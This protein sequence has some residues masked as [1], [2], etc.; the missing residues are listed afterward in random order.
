MAIGGTTLSAAIADSQLQLAGATATR[1]AADGLVQLAA[2]YRASGGG[3]TLALLG[4]NPFQVIATGS[5][6]YLYWSLVVIFLGIMGVTALQQSLRGRQTM[7]A[8]HPL[9]ALA[10]VNFRLLLGSLIIANTP[11]LY[12]LLITVSTAVSDGVQAMGAQAMGNLLQNGGVGP[13]TFAQARL[14]AIRSAAAR[15][16]IALHPAGASRNEMVQLGLWYNAMANAIN[17]GLSGQNLPG[18][19]PLLDPSI[20]TGA[21]TP[22]DRVAATV[23]RT[24]VQN[25]GPM[26]ADLAAL[27][28]ADGPLSI[29][30][31]EGQAALLPPLS[32]A[33][34]ADDSQANAAL[35][36]AAVPSNDAAWE[37]AR[38]L[39][40]R[41]VLADTL[42]YLDGQI[43]PILGAS[44]TLAQ[45]AQAWFSDQVE[46]AAASAGGFLGAMRAAVDWAGR[47]LGVVLTRLV[48]FLFT[49][50]VRVLIEANLFVLV[51]AMPFWL[52]P[53]T[54]EAFYGVLRSLA[55]LAVM[56][57]AYQ[58]IMLFVD[59]LMALV[60]KYI[61]LGPLAAGGGSALAAAGGA[62]YTATAALAVVGSGGEIV[63]LATFCYL[64]TYL[65]LAVYVAFKTPKLIAVFLRGA[66]A[67]GA[68]LSTFAT[69]LIAGASTAL[70]TAAVGGGGIAGG[71]LGGGGG[72]RGGA[73]SPGSSA[74]AGVQV[75][76]QPGGGAPVFRP[77]LG[78]V[79]AASLQPSVAAPPASRPAAG[80]TWNETA[81]FG[82]RTFIENL[83][84]TSPADGFATARKGWE[85]HQKQK[86]RE[87]EARLKSEA[88]AE[89]ES[90]QPG[91]PKTQSRP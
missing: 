45:R 48:A 20:W 71:L 73:G 2:A 46:R 47:A 26:V 43:L 3:P 4:F 74:G 39:Y 83:G 34:A 53:A 27:P 14:E 55:S 30:F 69:G 19:L 31:P 23:G 86:E 62:A 16:A 61:L 32:G 67:A 87:E 24:L 37:A 40:G 36:Q 13:L 10:Q 68:F 50:A 17:G 1:S 85:Q 44:P 29:A 64:V 56:V 22:D 65:F 25:F 84:A 8:R 33:L 81:R 42:A 63:A 78:R 90:N 5:F 79:M 6:H 66:G 89:K 91:R 88:K 54:E 41:E 58:F 11:L 38:Q 28:A 7:T 82:L 59:A 80:G 72:I 35:A 77:Q 60:L 57:P 70:A 15:R 18:Q 12:A 76:T 9:A 52:L 75:R 51:L 49:A 21:E